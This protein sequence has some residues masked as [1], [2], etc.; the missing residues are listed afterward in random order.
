MA[1]KKKNGGGKKS[2]PKCGKNGLPA[3]AHKVIRHLAVVKCPK[4]GIQN[5]AK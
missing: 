1:K 4:D 3:K 2:C 5:V